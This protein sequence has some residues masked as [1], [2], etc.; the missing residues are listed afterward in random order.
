MNF[1]KS[2]IW[3]GSYYHPLHNI[4]LGFSEYKASICPPLP[5]VCPASP[6]LQLRTEIFISIFIAPTLGEAT[7]FPCLSQSDSLAQ[8][9]S[10]CTL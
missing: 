2:T 9:V 7:I 10:L 1:G 4:S 6:Q 8:L 3:L 5:S